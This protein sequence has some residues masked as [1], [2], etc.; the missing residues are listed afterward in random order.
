LLQ[1]SSFY[2]AVKAKIAERKHLLFGDHVVSDGFRDFVDRSVSE[3]LLV[4]SEFLP[5]AVGPDDVV[6]AA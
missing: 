6:E 5:C 4:G 1:D 3:S 2:F